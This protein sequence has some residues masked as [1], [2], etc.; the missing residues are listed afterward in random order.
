MPGG[1][2]P[3]VVE[4][5]ARR[6]SDDYSGTVVGQAIGGQPLPSPPPEAQARAFG[7]EDLPALREQVERL[8]IEE[9]SRAAARRT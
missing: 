5:G 3:R 9:G 2:H 4:G 6:V 8:A 1:T 7:E